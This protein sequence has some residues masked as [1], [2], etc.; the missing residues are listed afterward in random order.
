MWGKKK[1]YATARSSPLPP[2]PATCTLKQP[3]E[4]LPASGCSSPRLA[5]HSS[6]TEFRPA[7]TPAREL[8]V[9]RR[10]SQATSLPRFLPFDRPRTERS[11]T[12]GHHRVPDR[13]K[14][15]RQQRGDPGP[16]PHATP[17]AQLYT[18]SPPLPPYS[19]LAEK[20]PSLSH[21]GPAGGGK[22]QHFGGDALK[23]K[24]AN[25]CSHRHCCVLPARL[26]PLL[27]LL[28]LLRVLISLLLAHGCC[29][30]PLT[31]L[32]VGCYRVES[33]IAT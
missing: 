11:G 26:L 12:L 6:R 9:V 21:T 14:P 3:R 2:V 1:T 33:A 16:L 31:S 8:V 29:C 30:S 20:P 13:E 10:V 24:T 32:V 18:L 15:G 7:A 25:L 23:R 4:A 28:R 22:I 5:T 19:S 17:L 27:W